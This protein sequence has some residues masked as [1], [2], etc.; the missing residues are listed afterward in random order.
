MCAMAVGAAGRRVERVDGKSWLS[1]E[2][3]LQFVINESD[4]RRHRGDLFV[5]RLRQRRMNPFRRIY[6]VDGAVRAGVSAEHG[7]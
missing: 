1:C 4:S 6:G 3:F 7:R 2:S 5:D